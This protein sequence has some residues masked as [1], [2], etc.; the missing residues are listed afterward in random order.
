V[1]LEREPYPVD[2]VNPVQNCFAALLQEPR[3]PTR[4]KISSALMGVLCVKSALVAFTGAVL[5]HF[6]ILDSGFWKKKARA[7][8]HPGF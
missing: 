8:P 6:W 1:I 4:L 7:V 5:F 2:P 3:L